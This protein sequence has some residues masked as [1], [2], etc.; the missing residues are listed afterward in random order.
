MSIPLDQL[1]HFIENIVKQ[2]YDK[3]I[4]VYRFSP[5]GSKNI[6]DLSMLHPVP[7]EKFHSWLNL[8]AELFCNDQEPLNYD[9]YDN[10]YSEQPFPGLDWIKLLEEKNLKFSLYNLRGCIKNIWDKALLLHSEQRSHQVDLYKNCQFI[11][12]Y[13]WSHA[14]IAQDWFRYA[15]HVTQKKNINKTFLIYNRAWAGTR[16]YRLKFCEKLIAAGLES[17]CRTS[18]NPFEP[19]LGI[20]YQQH[21]FNNPDWKP[22]IKLENY[23]ASSSAHSGYSA[24]FEMQ[25][26]NATQI[27]IVLETLFDDDRLHLTEKSLRPIAC[28]QPFIL[29]STHGSLEYLKSYGFQSFNTVWDESYD[30]IIDPYT[31]L[32]AIVEL[33][34]NISQWDPLMRQEKMAQAEIICRQNQARFFSKKFTKSITDELKRN[35]QAGLEEMESTNTASLWFDKRELNYSDPELFNLLINSRPQD[36]A[37]YVF[38]LAKTYYL[39]TGKPL[40]NK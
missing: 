18:I 30:S 31:R 38:D 13:Y 34:H 35:L 9:L 16:E 37:D 8:S 17:H 14:F 33:M 24:M 19:E 7:L 20:H 32:N 39:R 29:A 25:D 26:Y 22:S 11:P 5:N 21:Q 3:Q 27:E 6:N 4:I 2:V 23:F 28:G 1:Y 15:Q 40:P 36:E 12:V 10:T